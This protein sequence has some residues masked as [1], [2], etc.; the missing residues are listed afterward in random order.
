MPGP[1]VPAML[2]TLSNW[3][4]IEELDP[5]AVDAVGRQDFKRSIFLIRNPFPLIMFRAAK[6][7]IV[8]ITHI[9]ME[10]T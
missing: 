5:I 10:R 1:V 8:A 6:M 4:N 2:L 7:Q 9:A 3:S